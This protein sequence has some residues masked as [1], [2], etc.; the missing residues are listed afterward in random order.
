MRD[1]PHQVIAT[2]VPEP[3]ERAPFEFDH[4][5]TRREA[6]MFAPLIAAAVTLPLVATV[7]FGLSTWHL[8]S[9][10]ASLSTTQPTTFASRWPARE[11]P[12]VVV[13]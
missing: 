13:R 7:L 6:W 4:D 3:Y 9:G 12:L 5:I 1:H 11:M 8:A 2:D 10:E